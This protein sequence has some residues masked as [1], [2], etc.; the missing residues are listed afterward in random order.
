MQAKLF[1][2]STMTVD[3]LASPQKEPET[4]HGVA[5]AGDFHPCH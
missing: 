2:L 1:T 4:P 3:N 5:V